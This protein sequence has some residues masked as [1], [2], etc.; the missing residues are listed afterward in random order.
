MESVINGK[1]R[2][3]RLTESVNLLATALLYKKQSWL[4][5]SSTLASTRWLDIKI[6]G[7]MAR[8]EG[9]ALA[10]GVFSG[11]EGTFNC[12]IISPQSFIKPF[13][14]SLV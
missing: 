7:W 1:H 9:K 5:F 13:S 2:K 8:Y 14:Y 12:L 3:I 10:L 4:H 11:R 6:D